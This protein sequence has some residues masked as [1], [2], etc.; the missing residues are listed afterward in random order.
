MSETFHLVQ[1]PQW[2]GRTHPLIKSTVLEST[3]QEAW[4]LSFLMSLGKG[5]N[6]ALAFSKKGLEAEDSWVPLGTAGFVGYSPI[7]TNKFQRMGGKGKGA[8][9]YSW[10]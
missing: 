1:S 9:P 6:P 4:R 7:A 3:A 5:K 8:S 2:H 10:K